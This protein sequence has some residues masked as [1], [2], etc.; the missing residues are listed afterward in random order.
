MMERPSL[1]WSSRC[2]WLQV[3][4]SQTQTYGTPPGD[5]CCP[6]AA[7]RRPGCTARHWMSLSWPKKKRWQGR[8]WS[9]FSLLKT[10]PIAPV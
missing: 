9:N 3:S 5:S 7:K 2:T 8:P 1:S 6:V 10:M 4:T